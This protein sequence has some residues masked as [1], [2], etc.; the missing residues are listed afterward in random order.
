M[1]KVRIKLEAA[2]R[3]AAQRI[4]RRYV[5]GGS[6]RPSDDRVLDEVWGQGRTPAGNPRCVGLTNGSPTYLM[7]DVEVYPETR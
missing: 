7:F 2:N 6:H 5:D 4:L 3:E 1:P